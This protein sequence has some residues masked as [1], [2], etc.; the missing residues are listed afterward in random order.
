VR[1]AV[2]GLGYVGCVSAACLAR[3]G[4]DVTGVDVNPLKVE[5]VNRG[6]APVIEP[7]LEALMNEAR[8][9]GRLEATLDARAAVDRSEMSLVCVG[10]PSRHN[11][12]LDHGHVERVCAQIGDALRDGADGH[13][14]VVR[15]TVLPGT[16]EGQVL[17]ILEERSGRRAGTG[18]GV[19]VNPE[20]LR[21]GSAI[22][23]Y[24]APGY[25][26][27]GELD[28]RSGDAVA[29]L[30]A[31]IAAPLVRTP[32]RTA[33]MLKYVSNA[34][35]ALKVAFA[36]EIGALCKQQ[37]IDGQELMEL[38]CRDRTLNIS[39]AYLRP[40]FAFGGSCLPKDL[41]ALVYRAKERDVETPLLD[42]VLESNRR[43][44]LRGLDLVER[45]GC[46]RPGIL[47]LS[48]KAGTDDVRESPNVALVE[49][50]VGRGYEVSV[51]D[52][53]VV[54]ERL[55]GANRASLERELP[56]IAAIMRSSLDDV[57]AKSDVIVVA[58]GSPA[59]RDVAERLRPGQRLIDLVGIAKPGDGD[60]ESYEGLCW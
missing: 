15:S 43:H 41:R 12:S 52:E 4:H 40:G 54:P 46:R 36:N 47:G 48:F 1:V 23:D 49:T 60:A 22:A 44:L 11:G 56:H 31:A 38:F 8:R 9:R 6:E 28:A 33:E 5:Q 42:A 2:F 58:N 59:F 57:L 19:C 20:F 53:T 27:I 17:P 32:I 45:S 18:F 55:V 29:E 30:Y 7:G 3:D 16:V 35:H 51:Y 26:A 39:A 25:V 10:T 50:L 13:V 37:G 21:E 14:V 34:F 24:D